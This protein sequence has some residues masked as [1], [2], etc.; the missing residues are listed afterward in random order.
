M[1][2][3]AITRVGQWLRSTVPG[4]LARVVGTGDGVA[5]DDVA[6]VLDA[7]AAA[8]RS[9]ATERAQREAAERDRDA[10]RAVVQSA[11]ESMRLRD[12]FV[13][14]REAGMVAAHGAPVGTE[15]PED[16][17]TPPDGCGDHWCG[18]HW[19]GDHWR[20]GWRR[21][22]GEMATLRERDAAVARADAA[23]GECERLRAAIRT[24]AAA[25]R[26]LDA[27]RAAISQ[28]EQ[29]VL[30]SVAGQDR[31][32]VLAQVDEA[33]A[34]AATWNARAT[35]MESDRDA[36]VAQRE[37]LAGAVRAHEEAL[38]EY[39][40]ACDESTADIARWLAG[41]DAAKA[42]VATAR[43]ARDA[44]LTEGEVGDGQ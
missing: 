10:L 30:R 12:E 28:H 22:W 23:E 9:A 40:A 21:G 18:D 26:A 17:P 27:S 5:T 36:A 42:K 2:A 25:V 16:T 34:E 6:A 14:G 15:E 13:R 38:A 11:A 1:A 29:R 3:D 33:R 7:L 24:Q 37:A 35:A 20:A 4:D 8:Q 31:A 19:R 44:L 39:T 43:A 32:A 41:C